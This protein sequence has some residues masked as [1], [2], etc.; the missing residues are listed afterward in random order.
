M[1][2]FFQ[3]LSWFQWG[4]LA[5]LVIGIAGTVGLAVG[6]ASGAREKGINRAIS[7][8]VDIQTQFELGMKDFEAG[9]Y[10]LAKQRFDYV[11][12][13]D[14]TFPGVIE[15]L[16]KTLTQLQQTVPGEAEVVLPTATLSPTPDLRA[17]EELFALAQGQVANQEWINLVQTLLSLRNI[18]PQY[19]V[20]EIDRM[21]FLGLR[22]SGA[23]KI[24]DLGDLE[25]GLYDLALAEAFT[26]LDAQAGIYRDWARLYQVGVSF[27]GVFPDRAA[28]YFSQLAVAAP[29]LR[30]FSG[31]YAKDRYRMA[32]VQY[33]DH[34]AQAGDW[35]LAEEQYQLAQSLSEDPGLQPT[36]SYAGEQCSLANA[37]PTDTP[38]A[39]LPATQTLEMTST[40]GAELPTATL[41]PE[42]NDTPTPTQ[43]LEPTLEDTPALPVPTETPTATSNQGTGP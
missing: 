42:F 26:P 40:P 6:Y 8:A 16:A 36:A 2:N 32:L 14:P 27:W 29:Y 10:D 39:E 33:G 1:K 3:R 9:N 37:P 17:V 13:Q 12:Q 28:Y 15:M 7:I 41:T 25:G 18:D 21:L 11:L 22:F 34:L 43:T 4:L 19:Q 24:L 30:D 38:S 31:I 20:V 35:C 23:Q 5:A